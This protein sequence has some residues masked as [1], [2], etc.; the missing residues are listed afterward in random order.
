MRDEV[1]SRRATPLDTFTE[2]DVDMLPTDKIMSTQDNGPSG[3]FSPLPSHS[4][5]TSVAPLR[6]RSSCATCMSWTLS[7]KPFLQ[8]GQFI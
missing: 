8:S 3:I 7:S 2:V 5:D 1:E 6:S 4:P